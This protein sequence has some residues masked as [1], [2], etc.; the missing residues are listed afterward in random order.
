MR[1]K[2]RY[3]NKYH[4]I[5][6]MVFHTYHVSDI[7]EFE[8]PKEYVE[9]FDSQAIWYPFMRKYELLAATIDDTVFDGDGNSES[10]ITFV[11]TELKKRGVFV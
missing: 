4:E 2:A 6:V 1:I 8:T 5:L 10:I 9:F 11:K 7:G 3:R